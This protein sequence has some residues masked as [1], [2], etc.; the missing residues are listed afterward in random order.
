MQGPSRELAA[1][2]AIAKAYLG[3]SMDNPSG[4]AASPD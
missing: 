1:S 2:D 3:T 4:S